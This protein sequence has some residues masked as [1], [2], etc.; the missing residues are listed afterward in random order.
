MVQIRATNR[1]TKLHVHFHEARKIQCNNA[2]DTVQ[3]HI[4]ELLFY[5]ESGKEAA[6]L[7][8]PPLRT[9]RESFPS[10]GSSHC[11][12]PLLRSRFT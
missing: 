4:I 8:L 1:T 12:A 10:F 3:A 7:P 5:A 9:E 11:K 6:L 2:Q